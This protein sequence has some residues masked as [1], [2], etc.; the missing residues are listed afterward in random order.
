MTMMGDW[1][2][3][4]TDYSEETDPFK[5]VGT[6]APTNTRA[7]VPPA[8]SAV[9]TTSALVEDNVSDIEMG[10]LLTCP[11][12]THHSGRAPST[13]RDAIKAS[14]RD[15]TVFSRFKNP[16]F[17]QRFRR[18]R[19]TRDNPGRP[20]LLH[21]P[22]IIVGCSLLLRL[23]IS[24]SYG[25][26]WFSL[27]C[28]MTQGFYNTS[29]VLGLTCLLELI[30]LCCYRTFSKSRNLY[31][32]GLL[33]HSALL[34]IAAVGTFW[35]FGLDSFGQCGYLVSWIFPASLRHS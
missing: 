11:E 32:T 28:G 22:N 6:I 27:D 33:A 5:N 15:T 9:D 7:S 31:T 3:Q 8:Y 18:R 21:W 30:S 10:Q 24:V 20:K 16:Q 1:A 4:L 14:R 12:E 35:G 19:S 13:D 34:W 26:L 2:C 29:T 25:S 23:L 17:A